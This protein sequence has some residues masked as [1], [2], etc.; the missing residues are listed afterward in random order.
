LAKAL[1][2]GDKKQMGLG[3]VFLEKQK[4]EVD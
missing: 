4:K 3:H 1:Q 2:G